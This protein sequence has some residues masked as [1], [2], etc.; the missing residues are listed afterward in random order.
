M[1][2]HHDLE[3]LCLGALQDLG[4]LGEH[5]PRGGAKLG[6]AAV[7]E[8]VDVAFAHA[9]LG[10]KTQVRILLGPKGKLPIDG[11]GQPPAAGKL[12]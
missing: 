7:E 10:V 4:Q 2:D 8:H 11:V 1:A 12:G 9:R 3:V 5:L 6:L